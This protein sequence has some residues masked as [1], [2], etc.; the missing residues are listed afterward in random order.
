MYINREIEAKLE[1]YLRQFKVVLVT[2]GRQTGKTA[3]LK[4]CPSESYEYTT[5]DDLNELDL[6][7]S[8]PK[9]FLNAGR[10]PIIVDEVQQPI[11]VFRSLPVGMPESAGCLRVEAAPRGRRS[12]ASGWP[13]AP[14]PQRARG[15]LPPEAVA[16]PDD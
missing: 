12:V 4:H 13:S 3:M 16:V 8:D 2:G 15:V 6:A 9:A 5:L 11:T 14:A 10:T 1:S 7:A